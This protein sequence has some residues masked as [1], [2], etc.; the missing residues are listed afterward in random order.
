MVGMT[1]CL[2]GAVSYFHS[3]KLVPYTQDLEMEVNTA[4]LPPLEWAQPAFSLPG[5]LAVSF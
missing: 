2:L 5:F 3:A 1:E 4:T